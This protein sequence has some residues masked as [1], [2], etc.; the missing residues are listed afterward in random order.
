[1]RKN[2][3]KRIE[4]FQVRFAVQLVKTVVVLQQ[5]LLDLF[6]SPTHQV[7]EVKTY[8]ECNFAENLNV[9]SILQEFWE[10]REFAGLALDGGVSGRAVRPRRAG[11]LSVVGSDERDP[12]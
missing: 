7:G 3:E 9:S 8:R 4:V 6:S 11:V 10:K 2:L 12:G 5:D 1:M